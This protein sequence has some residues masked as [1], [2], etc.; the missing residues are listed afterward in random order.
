MILEGL[1]T[2]VDP[3]GGMHLAAMGPRIDEAQRQVGRIDRLVLRPF[4]TS[5]TAANLLRTRAGVFHSSDDVLLVARV[6]AGGLAEPPPARPA[7]AVAGFVLADACRAWEFEIDAVDDS[8]QRLSL[9]ARVVAEHAGRPFLGFNR[10]AHAVVEA[11]ILATRL[12]ILEAADVARQFGQLAVLV[13][14]TGGAREQEAFDL[15]ATVVDRGPPA[16]I[17]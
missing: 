5:Q 13:E 6:V 10:A 17:G 9:D 1:V 3:A 8:G 4:P 14:K 12:H 11:A 15:L 2:T 16:G 7:T